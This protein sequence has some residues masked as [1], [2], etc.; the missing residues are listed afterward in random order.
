MRLH[1][2]SVDLEMLATLAV[3]VSGSVI[4][5]APTAFARDAK[6]GWWTVTLSPIP[7]VVWNILWVIMANPSDGARRPITLV[8]GGLA[9]ALILLGI[10]EILKKPAATQ[11]ASPSPNVE[12]K[13]ESGPNIYAPDNK[14]I[15]TPE[16]LERKIT[17]KP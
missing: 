1:G 5:F 2:R 10:T 11:G 4:R 15:I 14:G 16:D 9:G 8:I 17:A 12:Q 7:L 6:F 3:L 13:N